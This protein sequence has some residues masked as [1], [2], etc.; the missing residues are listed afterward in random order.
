M[1]A[2][3]GR[4]VLGCVA[5]RESCQEKHILC[6]CADDATLLKQLAYQTLFHKRADKKDIVCR[7]GDLQ[8]LTMLNEFG[9]KMDA[10]YK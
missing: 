4:R 8:M 10:A 1:V 7:S 9:F 5:F 2:Q 6:M 3:F